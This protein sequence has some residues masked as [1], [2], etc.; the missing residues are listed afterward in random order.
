MKTVGLLLL[1][2][3]AVSAGFYGAS[4]AERELAQTAALLDLLR[5]LRAGVEKDLPFASLLLQYGN[6][7]GGSLSRTH[8]LQRCGFLTRL[9]EGARLCDA[10]RCCD[11]IGRRTAALFQEL[12]RSLENG[13]GEELSRRFSLWERSLTETVN[14]LGA[15]VKNK[16]KV[17]VTLGVCAGLLLVI[18]LW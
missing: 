3:V 4:M 8:P 14:T 12:E 7:G 9:R 15:T 5:Y 16:Q 18:L 1:L 6:T 13:R 17:S 2:A 10:L 11:A